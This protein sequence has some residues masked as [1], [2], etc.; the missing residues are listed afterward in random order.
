VTEGAPAAI[1]A[2]DHLIDTQVT[3]AQQPSRE[4]YWRRE[5][6]RWAALSAGYA[7]VT[8]A[9]LTLNFKII[10]EWNK[11]TERWLE[12]GEGWADIGIRIAEACGL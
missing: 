1:S 4:E 11:S 2:S 10:R 8:V 6:R 7:L 5:H 12:V 9:L 3:A